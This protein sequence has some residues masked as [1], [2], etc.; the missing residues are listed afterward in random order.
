MLFAIALISVTF[1]GDGALES[2]LSSYLQRT[3]AGG[4]LLSRIGIGSYH[5][6]SLLGRLTATALLRRLGER[7]VDTAAAPGP[8]EHGGG[9]G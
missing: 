5:F 4:V 8:A 1:F 3:E 6:T 7:R 9:A 2:F